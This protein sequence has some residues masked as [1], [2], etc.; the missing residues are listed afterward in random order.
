[1]KIFIPT[2]TDEG[3]DAKV[4]AH[5][6]STPYFTVYETETKQMEIMENK[7]IPGQHGSG[8]PR[9]RVVDSGCGA[10]ITFGLG[11]RAILGL[12]ESGVKVYKAKGQTVADVLREFEAGNLSLV[13]IDDACVHNHSG[14]H[15]DHDHT[16]HVGEDNKE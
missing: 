5:F 8:S 13:T 1:M 9:R 4:N 14:D 6:G 10:V 7:K 16:D 11:K 12:E 2:Q 15:H 3:L